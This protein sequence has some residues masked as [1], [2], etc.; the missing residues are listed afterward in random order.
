MRATEFSNTDDAPSIDLV[1]PPKETT[2]LGGALRVA[3]DGA[4]ALARGSL[5][6]GFV[7]ARKGAELVE[8]ARVRTTSR[9]RALADIAT[10]AAVSSGGTGTPKR[11][12]RALLLCGAVGVVAAGG[13]VFYKSRRSEHPPVAAAPPS[14]GDA[15]GPRPTPTPRPAPAPPQG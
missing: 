14:L 7:L 10:Q 6:A 15:P 1:H 8:T 4:A 9:P 5:A 11:R 13:A 2:S 3:G 12:R